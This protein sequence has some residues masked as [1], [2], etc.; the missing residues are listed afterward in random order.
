VI[1]E[2]LIRPVG[3]L[4]PFAT[5]TGEGDNLTELCLLPS[6]GWEKVADRPDEDSSLRLGDYCYDFMVHLT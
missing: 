2:A 5:L 4:L 3:H 6:K 1:E